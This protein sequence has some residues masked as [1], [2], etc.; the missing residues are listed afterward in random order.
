MSLARKRIQRRATLIGALL[1]FIIIF[2]FV[3]SLIAPG[4]NSRRSSSSGALPTLTPYGTPPP[5]TPV[6][7]PTV[8]ANPQLEGELPY[9][10]STGLF[11]TFRPAG[12]DWMI[13]EGQG[14]DGAISVV[15]QSLARLA[16]IH[17]YIRPGVQYENPDSLSAD[18]LT[19]SYFVDAWSEYDSWLET[20]RTIAD[21][22][23]IVNFDLSASAVS[24][25][26]RS[27]AW[28]DG[29]WLYVS[30]LVVPANN[31][32]LLDL[33]QTLILPEF[34]GYPELQ[35]M[36][37]FWP[38]YSDQELGFL[39]KHPAGWQVVAGSK[40]R[41]VTF[42]VPVAEGA[43]KTTV[44]VWTIA[45]NPIDSDQQAEAVLSG[46]EPT[47][48][49]LTIEP[50]VHDMGTGYQIAYAYRDAAGDPHSGLMVL[51][52]DAHG[53]LF[54]AN[55]QSTPPDTNWLDTEHLSAQDS[56]TAQALTT[57]FVI[58]PDD[59]RQPAPA[60]EATGTPT[61]GE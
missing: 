12:D 51:L 54:V 61:P 22:R 47:A 4:Q 2:T 49:I 16:V 13:T 46:A 38:A 15:I 56:Q 43:G 24:Y 25:L 58:L 6:I 40:G 18:F 20:G 33:L 21:N 34:R 35:A 53:M 59:A 7:V 55:L 19:E 28:V 37:E 57:G 29:S 32:A 31:P 3:I 5:P 39:L 26:G 41:P 48:T 27:I 8:E 36:P 30:R 1:G 44:R 52:N 23:V 50:V 10:H 11:Q 9:I 45:D 17:N 42:N 60:L 14:A